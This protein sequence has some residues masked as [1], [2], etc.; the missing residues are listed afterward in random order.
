MDSR[1]TV[2]CIYCARK[3]TQQFTCVSGDWED[4]PGRVTW[5]CT[6]A[7]AC[8]RRR[9]KLNAGLWFV[10]RTGSRSGHRTWDG[11]HLSKKSAES[12]RNLMIDGVTAI[13]AKAL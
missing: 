7:R 13:L 12:A 1:D 10:L 6:F 2:V 9:D 5:R 3:G 4:D 11:P 8:E